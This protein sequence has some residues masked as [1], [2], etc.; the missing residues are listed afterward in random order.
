[1]IQFT[2]S[3]SNETIGN[4]KNYVKLINLFVRADLCLHAMVLILTKSW[5]ED[6]YATYIS[7]KKNLNKLMR[8]FL[9]ESQIPVATGL[10]ELRI[11]YMLT[12]KEVT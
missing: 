11:S 3:L 4:H 7:E 12:Y 6:K 1:M 2:I 5:I 8:W 9:F 10:F